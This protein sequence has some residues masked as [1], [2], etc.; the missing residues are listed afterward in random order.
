MK[1]LKLSVSDKKTQN[2]FRFMWTGQANG[3]LY[4]EIGYTPKQITKEELKK[5]IKL[6]ENSNI[7]PDKR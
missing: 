2:G 7:H 5:Y 3:N 1:I 6:Y 4:G